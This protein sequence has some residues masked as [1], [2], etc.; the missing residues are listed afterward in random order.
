MVDFNYQCLF[1]TP[2]PFSPP[3]LRIYNYNVQREHSKSS[4][5]ELKTNRIKLYLTKLY[6]TGFY[7]GWLLPA[8]IVGVLVFL[9][10]IATVSQDVVAQETCHERAKK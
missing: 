2:P 5:L 1:I 4:K 9:Y 10:G 3:T 8:A 7:T 6:L